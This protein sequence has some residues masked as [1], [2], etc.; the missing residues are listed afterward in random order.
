MTMGEEELQPSDHPWFTVCADP[1]INIGRADEKLLFT[2]PNHYPDGFYDHCSQKIVLGLTRVAAAIQ[3]NSS[4]ETVLKDV[5]QALFNKSW[6]FLCRNMGHRIG[7]SG[8]SADCSFFP[9]RSQGEFPL[10]DMY[11]TRELHA[12]NPMVVAPP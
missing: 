8:S 10:T 11:R 9:N 5:G 2:T 4:F 7:N 1:A 6:P 12:C 3:S